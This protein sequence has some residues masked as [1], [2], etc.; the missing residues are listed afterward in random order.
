MMRL[1]AKLF[2]I[3]VVEIDL[4]GTLSTYYRLNGVDYEV[5]YT[6]HE[7]TAYKM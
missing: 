1:L 3:L 5:T 4:D 2:G 7:I 6:L